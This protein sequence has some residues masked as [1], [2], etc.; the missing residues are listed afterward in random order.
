MQD[1]DAHG[2]GAASER[3]VPAGSFF[4]TNHGIVTISLTATL[5]L[6]PSAKA[7]RA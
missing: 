6:Y 7:N 5:S 3:Y 1:P 2:R 4:R